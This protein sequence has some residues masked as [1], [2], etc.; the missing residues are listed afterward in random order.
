M[1]KNF[2]LVLFIFMENNFKIFVEDINIGEEIV[3][4]LI[5]FEF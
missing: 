3:K 1:L 2:N 5:K 4:W